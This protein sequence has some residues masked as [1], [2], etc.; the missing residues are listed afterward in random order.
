MIIIEGVVVEGRQ[1][2]R[3]LGFPTANVALDGDLQIESGV[4]VSRITVDEKVYH[5]VTNIGT[6]PTV[7]DVERRSESYLFDFNGDLYGR[8]ISVVLYQKLRSQMH[9]ESVD[10]L[11]QQISEDI[12][13]ARQLL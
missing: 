13:R 2:G 5:G 3:K 8:K 1:L 6:N 7:G 4:Y 10:H 9:F 11:R 12:E